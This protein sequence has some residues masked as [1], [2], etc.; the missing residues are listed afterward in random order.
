MW[1]ESSLFQSLFQWPFVEAFYVQNSVCPLN[2]LPY[3]E[4][5]MGLFNGC[6]STHKT[7]HFISMVSVSAIAFESTLFFPLVPS[8][9]VPMGLFK[10]MRKCS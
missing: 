8:E 6:I 4:L 9:L 1:G 3:S 2:S 10:W 5:A 7:S